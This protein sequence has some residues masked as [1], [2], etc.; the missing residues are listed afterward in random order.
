[1][2]HLVCE[3]K[4]WTVWSLDIHI[5]QF[6]QRRETMAA[7]LTNF[8]TYCWLDRLVLVYCLAFLKQVACN[9]KY[10]NSATTYP[11]SLTVHLLRGRN[12]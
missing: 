6:G 8:R 7:V 3:Q 12:A 9:M 11:L 2:V 5:S 4:Q 1:M 10:T